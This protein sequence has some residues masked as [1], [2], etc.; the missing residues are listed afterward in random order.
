MHRQSLDRKW[1]A[2]TLW[3]LCAAPA[4]ALGQVQWED[5]VCFGDSM[6]HND[7]NGIAY[8][9]PQTLYGADPMQAA[10]A[11]GAQPGDDLH[12]YAVGGSEADDLELQ[13]SLYLLERLLGEVDEGTLFCI[14]I[15]GNDILNNDGILAAHP[16]G[17]DPV[18][19]AVIDNV[20]SEL[21]DSITTLWLSNTSAQFVV[22]TVPDVTLTPDM[23]DATPQ[24]AANL[25]AHT[26]RINAY[27][28][29]LDQ[30]PTMTCADIDVAIADLIASPPTLFGHPLE[31]PPSLGAY[32]RIFADEI[33]FTAVTNVYMADEIIASVNAKWNAAIPAYTQ[34]EKAHL[35][36]ILHRN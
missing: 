27:I 3:V 28:R 17:A 19:D 29:S 32:H 30:S 12:R 34:V 26:E 24:E 11:K 8:E 5:T 15:G 7:L 35:A 16:P 14:E 23:W 33:H 22:W 9:N 1:L 2:R 18:A 4:P 6:T 31:A 20:I 10:F 13:V 21:D 25:R 36:R